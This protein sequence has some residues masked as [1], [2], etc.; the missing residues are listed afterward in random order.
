MGKSNLFIQIYEILYKALGPRHWWPGDGP[1]EVSVGAILTQN[2]AWKNVEKAIQNLKENNLLSIPALHVIEEEE[3][4]R[5]IRSSGYYNQKA[6]KLKAFIK[7]VAEEFDGSFTSMKTLGLT[8]L[9]NKLLRIHGIGEETADSIILYALE[10]PSFV[11]DAYTQ[12]IFSRHD[13]IG[14]NWTYG[15]IKE[16][17]ERSLPSDVKLF[18]EYHALI[19]RAGHLFCRKDPAKTHCEDCPLHFHLGDPVEL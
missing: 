3:L 10:M 19:V 1:L 17:F 14:K 12:R 6:R 7:V 15:R 4:S 5:L 18:N 8:S 2:T 13:L 16:E 11:V 9:R